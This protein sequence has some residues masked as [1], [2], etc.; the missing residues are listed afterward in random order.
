MLRARRRRGWL[1]T[2][3]PARDPL[4]SRRRG[5]LV[6]PLRSIVQFIGATG[7]CVTAANFFFGSRVDVLS[8]LRSDAAERGPAPVPS[9]VPKPYPRG[10]WR[11]VD[12]KQL[13]NTVL[14]L[15]HILIRHKDVRDEQ[16]SFTVTS[17]A[18]ARP[19]SG[20]SRMAAKVLAEELVKKARSGADF[21]ALAREFSEEPETSERGGSLGALVA[22]HLSAWPNVLDA[23]ATLKVGEVSDVVETPF[24]YHVLLRRPVPPE[25]TVTGSHVVIGHSQAPWLRLAAR[26]KVPTRSRAEAWAI[27]RRLF[28]E[29]RANPGHFRELVAEYSEHRDASRGGDFGTW[30]TREPSGYPREVETLASLRVGETA[31]PLDT[32]FGIQIILREEARPRRRFAMEQIQIPFDAT[33][34]DGDATARPAIQGTALKVAEI[35]RSEP[36]R[37]RSFQERWCCL[38]VVELIEGREGPELERMLTQLN[39]GQI[40]A[41]PLEEPTVQFVIVKRRELYA[42]PPASK[43]RFELPAPPRAKPLL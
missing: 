32:S 21:A 8:L 36:S 25:A 28:D 26:G 5:A 16:V 40:A 30:S 29:A 35:L 7:L 3:A 14:W 33:K 42:L 39:P 37:F 22:R 23:V 9:D 2:A 27:A 13:D 4:L 24:G 17:W 34:P 18:S 12:A 31:A 43:P 41:A 10:A 15:S 19:T 6:T 20:R 11:E 1:V 38:D